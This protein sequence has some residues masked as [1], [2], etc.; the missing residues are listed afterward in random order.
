MDFFSQVI[1]D[2]IDLP[3][4]SAWTQA[5]TLFEAAASRRPAHWLI[6]VR[7]CESVG[8]SREQALPA[9]VAIG[10]AHVGILLVDDMLDDD[11]RGDYCSIGMPAASNLACFFQ[12]AALYALSRFT[13]NSN[14]QLA[15]L[16]S[17]N[18][19]Y[20]TTA[21]GQS[22][23]VQAPSSEAGYWE[24]TKT[25]SSPFFGT[26]LQLGALAG[27][28]SI[29]IAEKLKELGCL[30]GEMIQ[31]HDDMHDSMETP[32]NPDWI[33][34]RSPLPILFTSLV[35]HP[36]RERFIRLKAQVSSADALQEAQE[37]LIRCGAISYCADE[38][39]QRHQKAIEFLNDIPLVKHEPISTLFDEMIAPVDKLLN[40]FEL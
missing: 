26:A 35:Q 13:Q 10:C 19:M 4:I 12:A 7:A 32:A 16:N 25:K 21:Y 23:D 31:I 28:A 36:D 8:G 9:I 29:E 6:P 2:F 24:V 33:Q 38:L 11:P 27:D 34:G 20:L 22:L 18:T 5:E 15:A 14:A 3:H 37:I 40:A 1:R 30:Y 17:F 39:M